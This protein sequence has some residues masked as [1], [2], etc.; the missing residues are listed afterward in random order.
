MPRS[1][2][3]LADSFSQQ[4]YSKLTDIGFNSQFQEFYHKL[5]IVKRFLMNIF[6]NYYFLILR[7][8]NNA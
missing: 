3:Y 6:I 7:Y 1:V 2:I 8:G 5:Y 4:L